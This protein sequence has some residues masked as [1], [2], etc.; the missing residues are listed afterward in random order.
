MNSQQSREGKFR[1]QTVISLFGGLS[2]GSPSLVWVPA[3]GVAQG[4]KHAQSSVT[5][6]SPELDLVKL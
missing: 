4:T 6:S 1:Q 2:N 5:R 3:S